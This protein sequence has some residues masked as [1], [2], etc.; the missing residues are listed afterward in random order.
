[1][2][3]PTVLP[4]TVTGRGFN[5]Q[6]NT[7]PPTINPSDIDITEAEIEEALKELLKLL[8]PEKF[9]WMVLG[10]PNENQRSSRRAVIPRQKPSQ[11]R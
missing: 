7:P 11:A 5:G 6:N 9:A 4:R 8:G 2:T 3:Q 10:V 1:M